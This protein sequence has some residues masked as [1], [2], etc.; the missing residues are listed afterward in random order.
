MKKYAAKPK[1]PF[2]PLPMKLSI[3]RHYIKKSNVLLEAAYDFSGYHY[4]NYEPVSKLRLLLLLNREELKMLFVG[5][6]WKNSLG[7]HIENIA[8]QKQHLSDPDFLPRLLH[9]SDKSRY[10]LSY[11][12]TTTS[13]EKIQETIG[14]TR[15]AHCQQLNRI[16][17]FSSSSHLEMVCNDHPQNKYERYHYSLEKQKGLPHVLCEGL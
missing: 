16:K 6:I 14:V 9:E 7:T 3:L 8:E 13:F 17:T 15:C 12:P 11:Y 2:K 1:S 10:R 5:D 4:A